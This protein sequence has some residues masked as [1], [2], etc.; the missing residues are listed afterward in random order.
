MGADRIWHFLP[1]EFFPA[2]HAH[3]HLGLLL[4]VA[5][6]V[7]GVAARVYPM[8]LLAPELGGWPGALQLWGLALGGPSVILGLLGLR[9]ALL[10]G[11]LAVAAAAAAHGVWVLSCVRRRKRPALDWGLRLVLTG[12][13]FLP[14]AVLLG[15]GFAAGLLSGPRLGLAYAVVTLGGW[16]SLTIAGMML[17]IVPFLVWYR[18]YGRRA[19]RFPVPTLAQ[20]SWPAAERGAYALLVGGIVVLAAAAAAGDAAWIRAAGMAVAAGAAAFGAALARVLGHLTANGGPA[21]G[22]V[23]PGPAGGPGAQELRP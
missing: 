18:V 3:F 22:A 21:E 9:R 13:A 19:G 23:P 14:P 15:V 20:L 6:M 12:A 5:P 8:F 17:K 7:M 11:A 2:L 10:P 16:V 4:W 1:T